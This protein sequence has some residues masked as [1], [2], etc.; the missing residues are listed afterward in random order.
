MKN[1]GKK[2]N[3]DHAR[4]KVLKHMGGRINF[5]SSTDR[6]IETLYTG[7]RKGE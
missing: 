6:G 4:A 3:V 1:K 2:S 5:D 7:K